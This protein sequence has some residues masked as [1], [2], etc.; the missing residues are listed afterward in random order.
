MGKKILFNLL[1]MAALVAAA[2]LSGCFSN[3]TNPYEGAFTSARG[4]SGG[5]QSTPTPYAL[6]PHPTVAAT[7]TP[8]TAG[9]TGS[10]SGTITGSGGNYVEIT[11][12]GVGGTVF[13]STNRTGDGPYTISGIPDGIYGVVADTTTAS[14]G[15]SGS[16]SGPPP[17]PLVI[18]GG[19]AYTGID[20][21]MSVY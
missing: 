16:F 20:I 21:V 12:V 15:R 8:G 17:P 10:I 18:S 13:V 9:G 4:G 5:S 1:G 14:P 2:S 6:T 3:P 11:A 19:T 7:P